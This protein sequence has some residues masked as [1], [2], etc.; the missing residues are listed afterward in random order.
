MSGYKNRTVCF[1]TVTLTVSSSQT[2]I[3]QRDMIYDYLEPRQ[4]SQL[5]SQPTLEPTSLYP[6]FIGA[7]LVCSVLGYSVFNKNT[8]QSIIP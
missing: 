7:T 4:A 2:R 1:L 8:Y 6:V 3:K 5:R